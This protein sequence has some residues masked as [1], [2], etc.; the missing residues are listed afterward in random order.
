MAKPLSVH[1][2]LCIPYTSYHICQ[3]LC[4]D[5][6]PLHHSLPSPL[7]IPTPTSLAPIIPIPYPT[8]VVPSPCLAPTPYTSH[9][10]PQPSSAHYPSTLIPPPP[11]PHFQPIDHSLHPHFYMCGLCPEKYTYVRIPCLAVFDS[12]GS[13][14]VAPIP[15]WAPQHAHGGAGL[16]VLLPDTAN[17]DGEF[18]GS[19]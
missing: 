4:L 10:I 2:S 8:T 3:L 1:V 7:P 11:I 15:S 19:S 12:A 9:S 5:V 13:K 16:E 14:Y 17:N 6:H 18:E